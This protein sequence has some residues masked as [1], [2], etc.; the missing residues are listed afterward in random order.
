MAGPEWQDLREDKRF[1]EL[2]T[3]FAEAAECLFA[4]F[5]FDGLEPEA[6]IREVL[7]RFERVLES[8]SGPVFDEDGFV[9]PLQVCT[10]AEVGR[11]FGLSD[12]RNWLLQ[13]VWKWID[14][15]RAVKARRLLLDGSFVTAKEAPG[16]VDAVVLLPADFHDQLLAG[17]SHAMELREMLCSRKPQEVFAAEDEMD[18]WRWFGF[19][20]QTRE[21]SGRYKGLIE[22]ML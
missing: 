8:A 16:D 12:R 10:E 22:V 9:S 15:A 21:A 6:A 18:W 14:L 4:Q 7:G 19:F 20:S 5:Q 2:W 1:F 17:N 13:R 11:W 3:R